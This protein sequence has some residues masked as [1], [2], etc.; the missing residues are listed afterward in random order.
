MIPVKKQ[1]KE[2][3]LRNLAERREVL[4]LK[5]VSEGSHG[6]RKKL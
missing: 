2:N 4:N 6:R 5:Q 3:D 1:H